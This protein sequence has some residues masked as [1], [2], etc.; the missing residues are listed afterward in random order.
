MADYRPKAVP[1]AKIK[2]AKAQLEVALE[3]TTDILAAVASHSPR[4]FCVGFA[5]ETHDLEHYA[6]EKLQRK[7]LDLVVANQVGPQLG[8]DQDENQVLCLWDG[9]RE[10]L[11]LAPKRELARQI[12]DLIVR[13]Y[14][15]KH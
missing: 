10:Q 15:A 12:I 11:P 3:P 8:F 7:G 2:K 9:G 6:Q 1:E 4:P 5:A 14:E 13:R